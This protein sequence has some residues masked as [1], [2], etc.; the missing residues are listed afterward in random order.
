MLKPNI[1]KSYKKDFKRLKNSGKFKEE[2]LIGVITV[3]L[4]QEKLAEKHKD[5]QLNGVLS[6]LRECHIESDLLLIYQTD[7]ENGKL[8]LVNIGSHSD[9]FE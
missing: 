9:L 4:K 1:L 5:H 8:H 3:L 7:E 2:K 6:H